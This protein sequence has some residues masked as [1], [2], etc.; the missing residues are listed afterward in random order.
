MALK[1]LV[2]VEIDHDLCV[3]S[4]MCTGIDPEG[5]KMDGEGHAVYVGDNIDEDLAEEA[6]GICPVAAIKLIYED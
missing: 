6:A 5:F 3:G 1:R 2:K 4:S